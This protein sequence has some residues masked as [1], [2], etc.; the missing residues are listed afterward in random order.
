MTKLWGKRAGR[1]GG[2]GAVMLIAGLIAQLT[3]CEAAAE[4]KVASEQRRLVESRHD[5]PPRF[6]RRAG[7]RSRGGVAYNRTRGR[8]GR[9]SAYRSRSRFFRLRPF[10]R[11]A[12]ASPK[13]R[14]PAAMTRQKTP[15]APIATGDGT[16]G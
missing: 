13:R 1:P 5:S 12:L 10:R 15:T 11:P 4:T 3:W 8:S 2:L 7:C 16:Q 9:G 6:D 14:F